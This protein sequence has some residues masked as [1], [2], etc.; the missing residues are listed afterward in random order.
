VIGTLTAR[1]ALTTRV[2]D[3]MYALI[4][5]HFENVSRARFELDLEAKNWVLLLH[6]ADGA[7]AGFSTIL[8]YETELEGERVSVV[9]SGDTIVDPSHWG[10]PALARSWIAS[11]LELQSA[12]S[13][14]RIFWLLLTSG[15]RTYRFLPLF[16]RSFHPRFEAETPPDALRRIDTLAGALLGSEYDPATG[17]VRFREP[18]RLRPHLRELPAGRMHD[19]HVAFFL[20]RNPGHA[21]GD[22]LVCLTEIST[23]NLTRAG[24]RMVAGTAA[25]EKAGAGR[26]S[27]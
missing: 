3:E 11:V 2:V 26:R 15:F 10:S 12:A 9:Y 13:T 8:F 16:W 22:E 4:D 23:G 6:D 18:A 25:L 17:I 5:A 19:P 21:D 14:G 1:S 7:L 20:A 27:E 24:W